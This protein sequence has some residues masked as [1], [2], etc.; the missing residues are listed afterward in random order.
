[1]VNSKSLLRSSNTVGSLQADSRD[2]ILKQTDFLLHQLF[3]DTSLFEPSLLVALS[4]GLDSVVLLHILSQLKADLPFKLSAMH[5]HHGLSKNADTWT[6]FC[7]ELCAK[8]NIPLSV[9]RVSVDKKSG[10]G[11]EAAARSVRNQALAES[12]A[13]FICLAHHQN[14]QAETLLLQ[15]A[16]GAGVKGLAGMA[17]IDLSRKLLRPLLNFSRLELETYAKKNELAWVDDESNLDISFDRNFFRHDVLPIMMQRYPSI[18]QTLARSAANLA[19]ASSLLDGLAELDTAKALNENPDRLNL[20]A[21]EMLD[22]LRQANAFR[23]W[24]SQHKINMPSALQLQQILQQLYHAR[25]DASIKL[26]VAEKQ[27]LRRYQGDAYLVKEGAEIVPINLLWQGEEMVNLPNDSRL[28]FT[29]KSGEGLVLPEG[30]KLR[31]MSREG[32]ERFKP[33]FGR[34]SRTLKHLMQTNRV[35][36][37]QRVRIPLVYMDEMLV[38]IPNLGAAAEMQAKPNETG[39]VITWEENVA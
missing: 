23:W 36:P 26:K 6:N 8:L 31:I 27:Y 15:L 29:R 1:M 20:G 5:V 4:G 12:G 19:E 38:Y 7:K 30:F 14:D 9:K 3:A 34:P 37:W 10:L 25:S 17:Q 35:P 21:L 18:V 39:Y 11:I 22:S 2:L 28:I 16:R 24:L 13:D 33:E 32:S